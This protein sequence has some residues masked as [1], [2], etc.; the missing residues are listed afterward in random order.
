[1]SSRLATTALRR[2]VSSSIVSRN[3]PRASGGQSTSSWSRLV[4]DALIAAIGVR[5]SCETADRIAARSSFAAEI[6]PAA[7]TSASSSP[8]STEAWSSLTKASRTRSS[9]A[10]E[11]AARDA[12]TWSG[13]SE[14][15][16]VAASGLSGARSPLAASTRQLP[17]LLPE[18]GCAV[19]LE[20]AREAVERRPTSTTSPP[21]ARAPRPRLACAPRRPPDALRARRRR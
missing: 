4:T 11:R 2:S 20:H 5:R 3:S 9:S 21:A 13:S 1:M 15:V 16:P 10:P 8:S 19:E 18:H 7:S 14:I 17:L 6:A 12:S